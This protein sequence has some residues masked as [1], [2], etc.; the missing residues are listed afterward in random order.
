MSTVLRSQAG[1]KLW[2]KKSMKHVIL[3]TSIRGYSMVTAFC[4]LSLSYSLFSCSLNSRYF[5][6]IKTM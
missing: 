4:F 6:I 3:M 1:E 2:Y 5:G